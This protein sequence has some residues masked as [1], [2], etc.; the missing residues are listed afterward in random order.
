MSKKQSKKSGSSISSLINDTVKEDEIEAKL[1]MREAEAREAIRRYK[2][3]LKERQH[4]RRIVEEFRDTLTENMSDGRLK[5]DIPDTTGLGNTANKR[6]ST[7]SEDAILVLSDSHCGKY[8]LPKHTLGFG[9]YGPLK[10]TENAR[11]LE[12][13]ITHL[14]THNISNPVHTLHIVMP[15]DLVE[16][17][18]D[19][20]EEIPQRMYV[21]DQVLLASLVFYQFIARLALVVPRIVV[22]APAG[23]NHGRWPNQRKVPTS[24]RFSNLDFIVIG[25]IRSLFLMA[26]PGN[27]SFDISE[28]A[29]LVFDIGRWR[30]K[31]GHGDHLKG[32]DRAMGV[33][34]H[35]IGREINNTTQRYSAKAQ[36]VPDYYIMGHLHRHMS[37]PTATGQYIINGAWYSDDEYAMINSYAP[38]RPHQIFLGV[39]SDVGKSWSYDLVF[40]GPTK[41]SR[42]YVLPDR[43][44][45]K[46]T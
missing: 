34:A 35:S 10:F 11:K 41:P 15:G 22:H 6:R 21:C 43:L 44:R 39:H 29:F 40:D 46:L 19:H 27:V 33:P 24:G 14:L 31:I 4:E 9:D 1:R 7:T 12:A 25:Q 13:T 23:G 20:A 45:E 30:F 5:I 18:L 36:K 38:S 32:G 8:V 2:R 28:G 26:G 37:L 3:L 17:M 42:E 16:G